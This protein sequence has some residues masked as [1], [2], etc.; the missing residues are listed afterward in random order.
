MNRLIHAAL[1]VFATML[2]CTSDS[3]GTEDEGSGRYPSLMVEVT[4]HP[5]ITEMGGGLGSL[6]YAPPH[7]PPFTPSRDLGEGLYFGLGSGDLTQLDVTGIPDPLVAPPGT[8]YLDATAFPDLRI[9][10]TVEGV[11]SHGQIV[12][13]TLHIDALTGVFYAE[14]PLRL[15]PDHDPGAAPVEMHVSIK[16]FVSVVCAQPETL[17]RSWFSSF[18]GLAPRSPEC[19]A[20]LSAIEATPTDPNAPPA[21]YDPDADVIECTDNEDWSN[22]VPT[23]PIE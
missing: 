12:G 1:P 15:T 11:L 17:P 6:T 14:L 4:G 2:G 13:H 7:D 3:I 20:I 21:P 10:G 23:A 8:R 22:S 18:D 5:D 9:E 19:D 16:G